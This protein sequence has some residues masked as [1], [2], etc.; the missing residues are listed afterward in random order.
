[1]CWYDT[2]ENSL[3]YFL[4]ER[5]YMVT[6]S[7]YY[8]DE[9]LDSDETGFQKLSQ[10]TKLTKRDKKASIKTKRKEKMRQLSSEPKEYFFL[11]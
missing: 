10:K 11:G 5:F 3:L 6:D 2:N 7:S 1:M 4:R 8:E 9:F